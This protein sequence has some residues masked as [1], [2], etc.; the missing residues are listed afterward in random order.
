MVN[1]IR[2]FLVR[3]VKF[4]PNIFFLWRKEKCPVNG[5]GFVVKKRIPLKGF[6]LVEI[7]VV[8]VIMGI[9]ATLGITHFGVMV[10]QGRLRVA[11]SNLRMI[12]AAERVRLLETDEFVFCDSSPACAN[13]LG[14]DLDDSWD[15][16]VEGL[17]GHGSAAFG[18]NARARRNSGPYTGC[19]YHIMHNM[20]NPERESG[21]NCP[22]L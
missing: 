7:L 17:V 21:S 11:I 6:T 22:P 18:F 15:Y 5:L 16:S 4:S 2:A 20:N 8:I 13:D 9:L 14:V 10:E 12:Q 1:M 3:V 19:R